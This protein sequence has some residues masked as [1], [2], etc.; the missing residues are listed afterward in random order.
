MALVASPETAAADTY[1]RVGGAVRIGPAGT[2]YRPPVRVRRVRRIYR[3][4]PARRLI[5]GGSLWAG[6][7]TVG[8][9]APPPPPPR[10][11]PVDC[12]PPLPPPQ[13]YYGPS[14][15]RPAP[16]PVVRARPAPRP[17]IPR[18]GLG[19]FGGGVDVEDREAG[20]AF[21]LIGRFNV[22][23]HLALEGELSR[24][25]IENDVRV[26]NRAGGALILNLL[27]NRRLNPYLLAG[28]GVLFTDVADGQ[29]SSRD[30]YGE[31]GIG[32]ELKLS[33]RLSLSL[34]GRAG[35]RRRASGGDPGETPLRSIAPPADEEESYTR[36]RLSAMLY[37]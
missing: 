24:D 28:G 16:A 25:E 5:V 8:W 27:P 13:P 20:E 33:R 19:V 2:Y 9:A 36:G 7:L 23:R 21:G 26:D 3:P 34:E 1:V 15:Y 4:I 22:G 10:P 11:C 29:Y 6:N 18:F 30:P 37:F 31:A 35:A 12:G 32:V 14:Q 17:L